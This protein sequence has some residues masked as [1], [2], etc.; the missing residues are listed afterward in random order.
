MKVGDR[1]LELPE[2]V[3][4]FRTSANSNSANNSLNLKNMDEQL[5]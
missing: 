4:P 1:M 3:F 5:C 2:G